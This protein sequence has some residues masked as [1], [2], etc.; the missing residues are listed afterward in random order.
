[1]QAGVHACKQMSTS[2]SYKSISPSRKRVYEQVY[3]IWLCGVL[4]LPLV[5]AVAAGFLIKMRS[6]KNIHI[7]S[8]GIVVISAASLVI[9]SLTIYEILILLERFAYE[10]FSEISFNWIVDTDFGAVCCLWSKYI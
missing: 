10:N 1:M 7:I 2:A 4:L 6:Q 9:S 3:F 8:L 5:Y